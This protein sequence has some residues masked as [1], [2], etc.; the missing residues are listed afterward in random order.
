MSPERLTSFGHLPDPANS[1]ANVSLH[2]NLPVQVCNIDEGLEGCV[3]PV[4][5]HRLQ[6]TL[7][8]IETLALKLSDVQQCFLCSLSFLI[9]H[10][11]RVVLMPKISPFSRPVK[12]GE[13]QQPTL[14]YL[15]LILRVTHGSE[16][17]V[18]KV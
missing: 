18:R 2:I 8:R 9:F 14:T 17:K 13:A 5:Q 4:S 6:P 1:S 10:M 15:F 12:A 16:S 11:P 7:R 3:C